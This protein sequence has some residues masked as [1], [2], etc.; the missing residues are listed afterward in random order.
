MATEPHEFKRK[1]GS[2]GS[3]AECGMQRVHPYHQV[4]LMGTE[5]DEAA[6]EYPEGEK[7]YGIF[8]GVF[9][10]LTDPVISAAEMWFGKDGMEALA[11][12]AKRK[13]Q[14][15]RLEALALAAFQYGV[16]IVLGLWMFVAILWGLVW[17]YRGWVML[18]T[19]M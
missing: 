2:P 4:V 18:W 14:R 13:E 1:P 16:G 17:A 8:G 6:A 12:E 7:D 11:K 19:G 15:E 5:G 9:S 3:C 10:G